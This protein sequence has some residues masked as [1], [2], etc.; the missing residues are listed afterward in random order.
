[1]DV[2]SY[3][4]ASPAADG[5]VITC[6][7]ADP[8]TDP[9]DPPHE[10]QFTAVNLA[11][12]EVSAGYGGGYLNLKRAGG[13]YLGEPCTGS[14]P[15]SGMIEIETFHT[16]GI[17]GGT[18]ENLAFV[19]DVISILDPN[20]PNPATATCGYNN[21]QLKTIAAHAGL[22]DVNAKYLMIICGGATHSPTSDK[23][24]MRNAESYLVWVLYTTDDA[25]LCPDDGCP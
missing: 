15:I 2:Y 22:A 21:D 23:A 8:P 18:V 19:G 10:F 20:N 9:E 24:C 25:S 11:E 6:Q 1:M 17:L 5:T 4:G 16:G 13:P 14:G 12:S 7:E 3:S